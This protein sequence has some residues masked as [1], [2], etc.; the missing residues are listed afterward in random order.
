VSNAGGSYRFSFD[1]A[2]GTGFLTVGQELQRAD[3][4]AAD[5]SQ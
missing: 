3:A 4:I 2:G 1:R 5:G